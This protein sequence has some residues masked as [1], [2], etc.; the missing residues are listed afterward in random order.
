VFYA[1]W[2]FLLL[3]LAIETAP[4]FVKFFTPKGSYDE[5]LAM[6]EYIAYVEEQKRKSDLHE[7]LNSELLLSRSVNE[8]RNKTQDLI[9]DK[10]L[11]EIASAQGEIAEKAIGRW[12]AKQ[13]TKVDNNPEHFIKTSEEE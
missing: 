12:K 7:Q 3:I 9:N 5:T 6:N 11:G 10:I 4:I 13:L 1:Y 8:K 2:V